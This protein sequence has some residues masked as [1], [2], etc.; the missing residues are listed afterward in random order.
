MLLFGNFILAHFEH[1][2]IKR[3]HGPSLTVWNP[4]IP[5]NY[6][7]MFSGIGLLYI[8]QPYLGAV[9]DE[10]FRYGLYVIGGL[11]LST[12]LVTV[13]IEWPFVAKTAGLG[14]GKRSLT[15]T[16]WVQGVSNLGLILMVH[17]LGSVSA[18]TGLRQVEPG[19]IK[20]VSGWV[21]YLASEGGDVYRA[22]LDGSTVEVVKSFDSEEGSS[23]TRITIEPTGKGDRARLLFRESTDATVVDDNVGSAAQAAPVEYWLSEDVANL[24]NLTSGFDSTRK[25]RDDP[26]VYAGFWPREGLV[27]NGDRY[28][29][30]TPFLDL[31]WRSPIVLPDGKVVAQFGETIV[32]IDHEQGTVAQLALGTGGDVLLDPQSK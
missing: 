7:S 24:G 14:L 17:L 8:I 13:L 12:Y 16:I 23:W 5:A 2:L 29:L 18:L 1:W 21:Y 4:M 22:R 30:E 9:Y 10:P 19:E 32:L 11:W 31:Q 26:V 3:K 6:T 28:A 15:T 25:F 27:I 20:T